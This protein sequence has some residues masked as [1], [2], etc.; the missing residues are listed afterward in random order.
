[1]LELEERLGESIE[2]FLRREYCERHRNTVELAE[3]IGVGSTTINNWMRGCDIEIRTVSEAKSPQ[4]FK[5]PTKE[6]LHKM[7]WEKKM[8][9]YEIAEKIGVS[10]T[11]ILRLMRDYEIPLRN[12]IRIS[13]PQQFTSFLQENPDAASLAAAA[14]VLP[15]Q[16][17]DLEKIIYELHQERFKD[18][19]QVH[20]LLEANRE[21]VLKLAREG[22]TNLGKY[23]GEFNLD[24]RGIIPVLIAGTLESIPWDRLAPTQQEVFFKML[25]SYYSPDFNR[26]SNSVFADLEEKI[27][28]YNGQDK[29]LFQRVKEY[30]REVLNVLVELS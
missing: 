13:S 9:T 11:P 23:I 24:S 27:A 8:S 20:E 2:V 6:E 14:A 3:E 1:M 26:D 10:I 7:Y 12:S 5:K 18:Q 25:T 30:Y 29:G 28:Q 16:E 21:E 19:Q 15:G 22:Y 4:G 17:Y